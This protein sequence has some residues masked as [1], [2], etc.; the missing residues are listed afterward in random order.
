MLI[1]AEAT[2]FPTAWSTT[3]PC[4]C[5]R[6]IISCT[7]GIT[8]RYQSQAPHQ[9]HTAHR[10]KKAIPITSFWNSVWAVTCNASGV[11]GRILLPLCLVDLLEGGYLEGKGGD[12]C[13]VAPEHA[14]DVAR[15]GH[16]DVARLVGCLL[17]PCCGV[18]HISIIHLHTEAPQQS[19]W[20]TSCI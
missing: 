19:A 14:A 8:P 10:T 2:Y 13:A 18:Y 9:G 4:F 17:F 3:G 11:E 12:G 5:A 16:S 20:H 7:D 1:A 6:L 15:G